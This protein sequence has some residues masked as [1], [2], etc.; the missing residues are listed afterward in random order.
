M[1]HLESYQ[2][3]NIET[4]SE[5]I[6]YLD[7][8]K[9]KTWV[10]IDTETTGLGGYKK[11]Q[12][13]Q[14]AAVAINPN[15]YSTIDEFNQKIKL[16][17][18][19]KKDMDFQAFPG[20]M[21][22]K[23]VL[24][25][26]RY[27]D[28]IKDKKY[29]DEQEALNL[30]FNWLESNGD[31]LLVIQNAQFDLDMLGG[32]SSRELQ[33]PVLDTKKI[34][35]F[36]II[37]IYQKLSETDNKYKQILQKIGTSERDKGLVSSSMGNWAPEFGVSTEGYHDALYDCKMTIEMYKSIIKI[38]NQNKNLDIYKYQMERIKSLNM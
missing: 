17:D 4:V 27:G 31:P 6:N 2:D 34:L 20:S 7:S 12:L 14:I 11:Q 18:E 3:R 8:L 28:R 35:Q 15:N 23:R 29:I 21:T 33:Y 1:K 22:R 10:F 19:I 38:L 26:N 9:N 30:F 24:S 25:F 37:P 5:Y 32:R 13:T 16:T 36:Y